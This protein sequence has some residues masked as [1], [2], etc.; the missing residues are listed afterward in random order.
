M[1]FKTSAYIER[2]KET[3][4]YI[5]ETIGFR[6]QIG[7]VLGSGSGGAA[8]CIEDKIEINFR[9]IPNFP[10][11]SVAGHI[12]RLA[13]GTLGGKSVLAMQGRFH[14]YEGHDMPQVVFPIRVM[15]ALGAGYLVA[16]NAAG[17]INKDFAPG[18]LMIIKD[19]IS[20][21][22]PSPLRGANIDEF[23]PRF[24][25]M[26]EIY[27]RN[28]VSLAVQTA[29][30]LGIAIKQGVYAFVKGPMY[31]TPAEINAL[32]ILGADAVGMSTVPEVIAA[33]HAGMKVL[34]LSCIA[35][36][37]SGIG[38]SPLRHGEVLEAAR[39]TE[40]RL[41]ALLENM[42]RNWGG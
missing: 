27:D 25:D 41:A 18:D 4:G 19:H 2:V 28:L 7:I 20:L 21:F 36:M 16:V 32:R 9:D 30:Q 3:A 5:G 42:L 11:I 22:C 12:G 34:G 31:E 33:R 40:S 1:D 14:Y 24:P 35:N 37:T 6:P 29:R 26:S 23:G 13:A 8:D 10:D 17:G 39:R 38:G 15:R